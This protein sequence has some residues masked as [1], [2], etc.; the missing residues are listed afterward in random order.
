MANE[1]KIEQR[2]AEAYKIRK[3]NQKRAGR[4]IRPSA[5]KKLI[6]GIIV[7]ILVIVCGGLG[8]LS[9]GLA[10]RT[11]TAAK[12]GN[13]KISAAEYSYYYNSSFNNYYQQMSSYFGEQYVGID[14][15]KS[16]KSQ[17]YTDGQ[18]YADY[19]SQDALNSLQFVS[20]MSAEAKKAGYTLSEE[21]QKTYDDQIA[22]IETAAQNAG[23]KL[24]KYIVSLCGKGYTMDMYKNILQKE[25][26]AYGYSEQQR[27]SYSYTD[28][29]LEA[30]YQEN[31]ENFDKVDFRYVSFLQQAATETTSEV[32]LEQA[33]ADAEAFIEGITNEVQ[34]SQKALERAQ[35]QNG[36]EATDNSLRS[37]VLK[38]SADSID[39]NLGSWLFDASRKA[40][41]IELIEKADGTGYYV[42]MLVT[43]AAR[44]EYNTANVRHI[45]VHIN[46]NVTEEDAKA[47]AEEIF[48]EWQNGEHTEEAFAALANKYSDDTGS[49]TNGGLY[50]N[51]YPGEMVTAFDEWVFAVDHQPGDVAIIESEYGYHI[52]Y[53]VS[54]NEKPQW[55]NTAE[56]AMRS[57]DYDEWY[58]GIT[59]NYPIKTNWLGVLLRSEPLPANN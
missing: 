14:M 49:N 44:D 51:V 4:K 36:E 5:M 27:D 8:F 42:V 15:T 33:K 32:T 41:D 23:M 17:D 13:D 34:F 43:P 28:E 26:L 31:K 22:Q 48:A 56:S 52:M 50:E 59:A 46:D 21:D 2:K 37:D 20:A 11:I 3:R 57:A 18:T 55:M 19:F 24:D 6:A 47:K 35:E 45:L 16:L 54:M 38:S 30:Y 29:D 1:S 53:F 58:E 10:R 7:A 25:L 9:S 40:G 12:I 39:T